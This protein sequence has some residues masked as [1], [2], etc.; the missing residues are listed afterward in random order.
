MGPKKKD[1][2]G[3]DGDALTRIAIVGADKY[4]AVCVHRCAVC[5]IGGDAVSQM[6][7]S[8]QCRRRHCPVLFS[9]APPSRDISVWMSFRR[10]VSG[11]PTLC[12][13]PHC[14]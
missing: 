4:V 13:S 3:D 11:A 8:V 1:K 2:K 12:D 9:S 10:R 7:I 6:E 5:L 14:R